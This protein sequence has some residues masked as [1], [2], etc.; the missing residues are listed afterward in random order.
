MFLARVLDDVAN[1]AH[2]RRRRVDVGVAHHELFE[3]VVL[4]GAGQLVLAYALLFRRHHVACQHRQHGTVHG[5]GDRDLV[6]W[7]LVEQDLHVFHRV[8]GHTGL[9]HVAR[10][11]G[12]VGVIAAVGGQVKR[13]GHAL[14]TCGQ[15]LAVKGIG[16]FSGGKTRVL[17]YGPGAYGV[18]GGLRATQVGLKAGQC[19][20]VRQVG[21][22]GSRIQRLDGDAIGR[23]PVEAASTLPPGADLAAAL[24]QASSVAELNSLAESV[25]ALPA[26]SVK[27]FRSPHRATH[28][29]T[30]A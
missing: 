6:Q 27:K 1:D 13:H 29:E 15:R 25:M 8:D 19:I 23:D 20:G 12:V 9:T 18:H 24:F 3:D 30:V 26:Y 11:A 17:A 28:T 2:G 10:H 22:V 4:D 7:N 16:L 5:H 14:P 21:G